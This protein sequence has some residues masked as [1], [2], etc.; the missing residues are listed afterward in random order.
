M[1]LF[2][3]K[4]TVYWK[5]KL[6]FRNCINS[7]LIYFRNGKT[8]R[9]ST[10]EKKA[11]LLISASF[12]GLQSYL[13]KNTLMVYFN[14]LCDL[15]NDYLKFSL[16]TYFP[17]FYLFS[18]SYMTSHPCC[19]QDYNLGSVVDVTVQLCQASAEFE[20]FLSKYLWSQVCTVSVSIPVND[21][22]PF[23]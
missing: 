2:W 19:I 8:Q 21:S 16:N 6:N 15:P 5:E 4:G 3:T 22:V 10:N 23:F 11:F 7:T 13:Y 17:K 1:Q 9:V 12:F 14:I 18:S 20:N